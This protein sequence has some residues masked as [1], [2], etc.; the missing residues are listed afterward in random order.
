VGSGAPGEAVPSVT[1]YVSGRTNP[2][3]SAVKVGVNF[4]GEI[5]EF[6]VSAELTFGERMRSEPESGERANSCL[7]VSARIISWADEEEEADASDDAGLC[8][9]RPWIS[10]RATASAAAAVVAP[11]PRRMRLSKAARRLRVS[12]TELVAAPAVS[13]GEGKGKHGS[14]AGLFAEPTASTSVAGATQCATVEVDMIRALFQRGRKNAFV[15][16][17][18]DCGPL[19]VAV[20]SG[21]NAAVLVLVRSLLSNELNWDTVHTLWCSNEVFDR[22]A[23][24]KA[25]E[26]VATAAQWW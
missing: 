22:V 11:K 24:R 3:D 23:I 20:E 8:V 25:L 6:G 13:K 7:A 10:E 1:H 9:S 17:R 26:W 18:R 12:G 19:L 14:F 5:L 15:A 2:P 16:S 21:E 4:P